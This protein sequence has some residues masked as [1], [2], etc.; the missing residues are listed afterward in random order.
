VTRV[1][2]RLLRGYTRTRVVPRDH[3]ELCGDITRI[4]LLDAEWLPVTCLTCLVGHCTALSLTAVLV[5]D[6]GRSSHVTVVIRCIT[7]IGSVTA[8]L[9]GSVIAII[10]RRVVITIIVRARC[11]VGCPL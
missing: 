7:I 6:S 8:V 10:G 11:S 3:V 9:L 4:V 5:R 2:H 1:K